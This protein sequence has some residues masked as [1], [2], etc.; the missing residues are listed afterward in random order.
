MFG[1]ALEVCSICGLNPVR[2]RRRR[3]GAAHRYGC[4]SLRP[5]HPRAV[6]IYIF[7]DGKGGDATICKTPRACLEHFQCSTG[8]RRSETRRG[9]TSDRGRHCQITIADIVSLP[10]H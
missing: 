9:S 4:A 3:D 7:V 2:S 10:C 5:S 1:D 8:T 6:G